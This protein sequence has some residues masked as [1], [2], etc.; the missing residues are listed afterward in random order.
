MQNWL[1]SLQ[2]NPWLTRKLVMLAILAGVGVSAFF[3]GRRQHVQADSPQ[4]KMLPG[5]DT[6]DYERRVVA[7]LYDNLAISRAELGEYLIAR[8]GGERL[9]FLVNRKI[10]EIEC[11]KHNI[12]VTEAEVENRFQRDLQAF[13]TRITEHDFVNS[14]LRRFGKTLYEWK[15]DVIRPKLMMEKYVRPMVKITDQDLHEGFE[16]R[17]GPKVKC[18]MIVIDAKAGPKVAMDVYTTARTGYNEFLEAASKQFIPN[19]AAAKG[20]VPP[21]HKHFGDKKVEDIAFGMKEGEVCT[22]LQMADGTYVIMYCEKLVSAEATKR[23]EQE[24]VK[25][26]GEMF[27]LRLSQKIPEEFAKLQ[28]AANPRMVITKQEP[29]GM[30]PSIQQPAYPTTSQPGPRTDIAPLVPGPVTATGYTP[31]SN[32]VSPLPPPPIVIPPEPSLLPPASGIAPT[33]KK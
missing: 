29:R 11:A 19:L 18:R 8:F 33:D 13:G 20:E 16:A 6:H 27:E 7:Y 22:P 10:V 21:I 2:P 1:M 30:L 4:V 9:E 23:Y 24:R 32:T 26:E 12:I 25:L 17:Y 14:I 31:L 5:A 28:K 3:L 15:E